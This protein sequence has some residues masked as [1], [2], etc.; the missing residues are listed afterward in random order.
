V[1]NRGSAKKQEPTSRKKPKIILEE[2]LDSSLASAISELPS[3]HRSG[4]VIDY[5]NV[6]LIYQKFFTDCQDAFVFDDPHKKTELDVMRLHNAPPDWTIRAFEPRGMEDL[7]KYLMNMPDRMQKQTLCVMP[8]MDFKPKDLSEMTDCDFHIINAQHS[9]AASKAMIAGNVPKTIRKEFR[10]WQCFVV[11]TQDV[12]KLRKILAFY[13]RV[14][15]L[16]PFK[17]TWATNILASRSVWEKYGRPQ[18]KHSAAR[19]TDVR[20][21][22]PRPPGNDKQFEVRNHFLNHSLFSSIRAKLVLLLFFEMYD[23]R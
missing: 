17:P 5:N 20:T 18:P 16:A 10:T 13:N 4:E 2:D 21:S 14:N 6:N 11:W 3:T 22:A 15:H 19:V 12:D 1:K 8:K 7:K 9:V 23:H